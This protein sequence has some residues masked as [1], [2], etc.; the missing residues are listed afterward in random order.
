MD[1]VIIGA[2]GHSKDLEYLASS[3]KYNDWN[4]IGYLDDNLSLNDSNIIG[5]ISIVNSLLEK[6][7]NLKYTI[8]INSSKIRKN[9]ESNIQRIDRAANLI[10]ETAVI[11]TH[12]QYGNGLT[13]GPYSVLTTKVTLGIHVHINTAASINQSSSIGD[14][15]TVSPGA[16]ICGD[17]NVGTQTS[18]GAGSVIINFKN[19]G[20]NCTLGAGTVVIENVSD[21]ATV[22]GVPGREIKKFGEYI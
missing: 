4:I 6:Y 8:A 2:G 12:C 5:N 11:G 15:C 20:S 19:V 17:V 16:R 14:F 13:M 7:P 9:I 10:H 1:L 21:G 22:V 3:D 18:I